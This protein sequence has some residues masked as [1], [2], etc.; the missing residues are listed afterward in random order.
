VSPTVLKIC[1]AAALT[2]GLLLFVPA[3]A[4]ADWWGWLFGPK[5]YEDCAET[6]AREAK[7]KD[8]L[9]IL[10]FSCDS[11][12]RGRRKLTGGYTFYDNRQSRYFDIA[13]PNPTPAELGYIERQYSAYL[14]TQ[15][16]QERIREEERQRRQIDEDRLSE[17][18]LLEL[19]QQAEIRQREAQRQ[20]AIAQAAQAELQQRQQVASRKIAVTST[21]IEC[22][23]AS[24][25]DTTCGPY[26]LT[27]GIRNQSGETI[28]AISLGWAFMP[29]SG[30]SCPT[31]LPTKNRSEVKLA[32][33]DTTILNLDGYDAP[34]ADF[35][36][37]V[38]VTGAEIVLQR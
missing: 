27:I 15:A 4:H 9:A 3:A 10:L 28:S 31:S 2:T 13:G 16:E 33:N 8:A 32:P 17:V 7:S 23:F 1:R 25:S 12:F 29:K 5:D 24:I 34:S 22:S 38:R 30:Q 19:R 35:R 26:K 21:N 36:Y 37:C 11:K 6:A 18:R 20:A 14:A